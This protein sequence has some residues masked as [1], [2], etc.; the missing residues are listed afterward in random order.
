[1]DRSGSTFPHLVREALRRDPGRPFITAYDESTGARTELSMTTYANWV[2]KTAN[3]L[4]EEYLLDEGDTIR[5]DVASHWLAPVFVGAAWQAGIA[6]TT[7]T[8]TACHL[9]VMG[10]SIDEGVLTTDL[11]IV[12]SSLDAF[13]GRFREQLPEGVDDFGALWPGQPDAFISSLSPGAMTA[14][15][16]D[17][18]EA[19]SQDDLITR[20]RELAAERHGHRLLTAVHPL[21]DSAVPTVL[22]ALVS[23]GSVVFVANPRD[24]RWASRYDA[25]RATDVLPA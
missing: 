4:V 13:A 9:I 25:E 24:A 16:R 15:W 5:I 14:A 22:T 11:P 7:D 12:A 18:G 3:L 21:A 1:M 20:A 23:G 19:L 10:P 8:S 17:G 6:V 2:N